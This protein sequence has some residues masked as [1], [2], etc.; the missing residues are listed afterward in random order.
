LLKGNTTNST[1][2]NQATTPN[3]QGGSG[4]G[5]HAVGNVGGA[6]QGGHPKSSGFRSNRNPSF[7]HG[8]M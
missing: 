1:P 4:A 5:H 3:Y 7:E 8:S 6:A 2:I